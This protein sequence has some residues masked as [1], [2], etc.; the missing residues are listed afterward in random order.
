MREM[1][2]VR[3]VFS[4]CGFGDILLWLR[5]FLREVLILFLLNGI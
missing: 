1:I 3:M 4:G 2:M 5:Y